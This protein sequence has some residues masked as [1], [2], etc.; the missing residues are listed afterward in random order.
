MVVLLLDWHAPQEL[1][2]THGSHISASKSVCQEWQ[3]GV[4]RIHTPCYICRLYW[5]HHISH[6]LDVSTT[7]KWF[8]WEVL[9]PSAWSCA[10]ALEVPPLL[11][12]MVG[13]LLTRA[14]SGG[15]SAFV[16]GT[17]VRDIC[18]SVCMSGCLSVID[19]LMCNCVRCDCLAYRGM[20]SR[21]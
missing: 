20:R 3:H 5:G 15:V 8:C 9:S 18:P 11:R 13:W 1:G 21:Q 17:D 4:R 19:C 14:L 7:H 10:L 12:S 2:W 16:S 6:G